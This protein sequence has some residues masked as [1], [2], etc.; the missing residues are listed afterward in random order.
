MYLCD[1]N[2][3][4]PPSRAKEN[5]MRKILDFILNFMGYAL[6]VAFVVAVID[7]CWKPIMAGIFTIMVMAGLAAVSAAIVLPIGHVVRT[8]LH[9]VKCDELKRK[10]SQNRT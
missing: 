2:K 4:Q 8:I 10:L 9:K 3:K 7:I 5:T 6:I 1:I